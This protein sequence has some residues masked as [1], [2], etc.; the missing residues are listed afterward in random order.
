[1][2]ARKA[3]AETEWFTGEAAYLNASYCRGGSSDG[4]LVRPVPNHHRRGAGDGYGLTEERQWPAFL[5]YS[6]AHEDY[7]GA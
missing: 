1:M 5:C 7:W 4:G 6:V 3:I 2:L